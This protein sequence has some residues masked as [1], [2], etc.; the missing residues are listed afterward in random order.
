MRQVI[1]PVQSPKW[2]KQIKD[3]KAL[4]RLCVRDHGQQDR[5]FHLCSLQRQQERD[6][7]VQVEIGTWI[8]GFS[9]RDTINDGQGTI[10]G[11]RIHPGMTQDQALAWARGWHA[12]DPTCREVVA[13]YGFKEVQS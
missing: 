3:A 4:D 13:G 10:A 8:G 7:F 1:F 6:G 2:A 9:V 11:G 5:D 12:A